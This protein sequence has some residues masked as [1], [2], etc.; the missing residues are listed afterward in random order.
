MKKILFFVM[1]FVFSSTAYAVDCGPLKVTAIQAQKA[2]VLIQV[3]DD[4]GTRWRS[5]GSHSEPSTPSFQ[6]V[7]QQAMAMGNSVVLRFPDGYDCTQT[8]Y[9][10]AWMI[11]ILK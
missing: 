6:S 9:D 3:K 5:L 4:N 7:A 8:G 10:R 1:S 2:D 11:R